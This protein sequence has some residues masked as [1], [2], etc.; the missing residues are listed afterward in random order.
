MDPA[1]EYTSQTPEIT[2]YAAWV[3]LFEIEFYDKATGELMETVTYDPTVQSEFSVPEWSQE[4]GAVEMYKFPQKS[5]YTFNGAYYDAEGKTP[6]DTAYLQHPGAVD[7]ATGTAKDISLAVYVDWLEGEWYHIYT[8]QQFLDNASVS[9]SY[10][11]HADLDFTDEVWPTSLMHGTYTGTI[12]GNGHIF[13]NIVCTQ[14]NNNKNYTGLFGQLAEGAILQDI[15]FENVDFTIAKGTRMAGAVF[16]LL[17]GSISE[18]AQCTGVNITN[19][20]LKID[21]SSA[22]LTEDYTIG[23]VCGLGVT[24]IDPSGITCEATGDTPEKVVITVSD[25]TVTLEF[26]TD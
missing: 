20:T 9:G 25:T 7:D 5:G 3:P 13:K 15:T 16:G 26:V 10:V 8:A 2:L 23:L 6:V 1:G 18:E 19:S 4:T 17:A 22:F 21:S 24:Q 11:I 14:T 12:Q